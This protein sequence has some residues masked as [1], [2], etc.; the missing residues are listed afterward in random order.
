M[1]VKGKITALRETRGD[2]Q[3]KQ[4]LAVDYSLMPADEHR[5]TGRQKKQEGVVDGRAKADNI[6]GT[7]NKKQS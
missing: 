3:S 2:R 1:K 5:F 6:C 7:I 4:S